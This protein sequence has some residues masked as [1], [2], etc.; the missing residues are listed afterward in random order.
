MRFSKALLTGLARDGGLLLPQTIPNAST[1]LNEWQQLPYAELATAVMQP[2]VDIPGNDFSELVNRS[3]AT[4]RHKETA[5]VVKAGNVYILELFH[6]P[7]LAFKDI[8]LQLLGNLYEYVLRKSEKQ[9]NI[10]GATSGDTGSAAIQGVRNKDSIRI[11]IM[12]P[13]GRISRTQELQMTSV[14]DDNVH[15]L[16]IKGTFDDCQAIMKTIFND[17]QFRDAN[18]LGS[19]NSINWARILAQIV[20]YFYAGLNVIKETGADK[21][22][23]CVPTGNFGDIFAGYVAARMGL[24]ISKLILATN[25]NDILS[26]FFNSGIYETGGPVHATVSPSMDIQVAS[27]FERY[28]YYRSNEDPAKLNHLMT[29]FAETGRLTI[30]PAAN[31]TVD[32]LFIAGSS[33]TQSTLTTIRDFYNTHN[34]LLDPHTAVGISTATAHLNADEPT[35]CLATA[36]PAK[37]SEAIINATGKDIAHHPVIDELNNLPTRC[38]ALQ[39]SVP[40][41][42]N[43]I[44]NH[45]AREKQ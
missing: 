11:F 9:L 1:H 20:Y 44:M 6:G 22:R 45:I 14:L 38:D 29:S 8:A 7:T 25:E 15:N 18:S 35:I 37:F 36:H 41:V 4:F 39:A 32:S 43:Y 30:E 16:A 40:E 12:H 5:P 33:N 26:R 2:F 17:L 27:N 3:Y 23:F 28:L 13:H 10:L 19:V 42:R 24:P 34:Y 21:I 31:N